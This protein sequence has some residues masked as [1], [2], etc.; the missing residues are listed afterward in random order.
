MELALVYM[1]AGISSRFG[2]RIKAFAQISSNG[3]TLIEHSLRQALPAGFTKIIFIVGNKTEQAFKEKFGDSFE[4]VPVYYALQNYDEETRDRPWGTTDAV[5]SAKDLIDCP[6]ILANGDDLY[7]KNSFKIVADYLKEN[8]DMAT[9]GFKLRGMLSEEGT[10]NR[11][12]FQKDSNDYL[13]EIKEVLNISKENMS[14]LGLT[15]DTLCNPNLFGLRPEVLE[16]LG[17]ILM[18]FKEEHE[19]DRKIECLLPVDLG[20]LIK[21]GKIKMKVLLTPDKW[22]GVTNPGDELLVRKELEKVE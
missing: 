8:E 22:L 1:V 2:G 9:V 4:G 10:V 14:E 21:Q 13:T 18:K 7:G 6:F 20:D 11:G 16:Y 3:E 5:C 12:V 15:E 17:E 19:G